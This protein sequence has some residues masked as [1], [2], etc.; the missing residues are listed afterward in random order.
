MMKRLLIPLVIVAAVF[1]AGCSKSCG[2]KRLDA[3]EKAVVQLEDLA[4]KDDMDVIELNQQVNEWKKGLEEMKAT[5][6]SPNSECANDKT[7]PTDEQKARRT[8]LDSRLSVAMGV[9]AK[10]ERK[11][12]K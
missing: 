12:K 11:L 2:D 3:Y 6:T 5:F 10:T 7:P 4:R 1:A 8:E 9:L